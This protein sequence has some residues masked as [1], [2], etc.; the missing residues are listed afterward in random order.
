MI[1]MQYL[2]SFHTYSPGI[3]LPPIFQKPLL[4]D[5]LYRGGVQE[6]VQGVGVRATGG[7][8]VRAGLY[9]GGCTG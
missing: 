5:S 1:R 2:R 9:G 7:R 4:P 6:P 8:G 3:M